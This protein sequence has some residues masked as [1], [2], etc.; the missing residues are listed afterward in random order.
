MSVFNKL[1]HFINTVPVGGLIKR[2]ILIKS[3]G[4]SS[5]GYV[6]S[7][8]RQLTST[9][10]LR[11]TR[12]LGSYIMAKKIPVD[13]TSSELDKNH[14]LAITPPIR[15]HEELSSA[16][17]TLYQNIDK[18]TTTEDQSKYKE[19]KDYIDRIKTANNIQEVVYDI[20]KKEN[21]RRSSKDH[22]TKRNKY[23][24]FLL[25]EIKLSQRSRK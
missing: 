18:M 8:R 14:Y 16:L 6:D 13:I 25:H 11:E 5:T 19:T 24:D 7:I 4:R 9:G 20:I 2:S 1:I 22:K 23:N 10:Y 3:F 15:P 12:N 21:H 17:D